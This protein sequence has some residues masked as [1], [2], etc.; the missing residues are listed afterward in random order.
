[1]YGQL[2]SIQMLYNFGIN[3]FILIKKEL[4]PNKS[5]DILL[6]YYIRKE[7]W[8]GIKKNSEKQINNTN[9]LQMFGF[10]I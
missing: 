6:T 9:I 8:N 4:F 10:G 1:M 3:L 7:A 2:H 5:S